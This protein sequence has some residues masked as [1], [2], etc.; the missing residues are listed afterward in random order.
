M[1]FFTLKMNLQLLYM[2]DI[3]LFIFNCYNINITLTILPATL[4]ELAR[5]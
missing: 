2:V 3:L 4:D 5:L 1:L